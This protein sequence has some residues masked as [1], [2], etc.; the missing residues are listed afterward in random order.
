MLKEDD[1]L[2]PPGKVIEQYRLEE[3]WVN[4]ELSWM[5]EGDLSRFVSNLVINSPEFLVVIDGFEA[6]EVIRVCI[7]TPFRLMEGRFTDACLFF[8]STSTKSTCSTGT[9]LRTSR[10]AGSAMWI[11][12]I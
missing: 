3:G 4:T 12:S 5:A 11:T 2:P 8:N 10:Q 9:F 7:E 1:D 6:A